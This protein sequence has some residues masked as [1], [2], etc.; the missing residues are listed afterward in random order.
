MVLMNVRHPQDSPVV[1]PPEVL[2]RDLVLGE[3]AR[4]QRQQRQG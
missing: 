2:Q 4:Q 3:A 1:S